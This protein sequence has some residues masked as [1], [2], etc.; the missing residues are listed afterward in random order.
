MGQENIELAEAGDAKIAAEQPQQQA[1]IADKAPQGTTYIAIPGVADIA[2]KYPDADNAVGNVFI[3]R[4]GKEVPL[5][6]HNNNTQLTVPATVDNGQ[7][8]PTL[9]LPRNGYSVDANQELPANFEALN[10]EEDKDYVEIQFNPQRLHAEKPRIKLRYEGIS[11]DGFDG[12]ATISCLTK[13][14]IPENEYR[15]L[16]QRQQLG[17]V[18]D[19]GGNDGA[20]IKIEYRMIGDYADLVIV[21]KDNSFTTIESSQKDS[22]VSVADGVHRFNVSDG[23]GYTFDPRI[24]RLEKQKD[25]QK[26]IYWAAINP[27]ATSGVEL[28]FD[29][30]WGFRRDIIQQNCS[31]KFDIKDTPAKTNQDGKQII[32]SLTIKEKKF[33]GNEYTL[34]THQH[35]ENIDQNTARIEWK[36]PTNNLLYVNH[37]Q[38]VKHQKA[39]IEGIL[40]I[41][42]AENFYELKKNLLAIKELA[43]SGHPNWTKATKEAINKIFEELQE[44][45]KLDPHVLKKAGL[46][47]TEDEA[48]AQAVGGIQFSRGA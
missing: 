22:G 31:D 36:L 16:E 44:Q 35:D 23:S 42:K 21:S 27:I 5:H 28:L 4:D 29:S 2:I 7:P 14:S 12:A 3:V 9:K 47:A 45:H 34:K 39:K 38:K 6:Q 24:G 33:W 26:F 11:P 13:P 40:P 20:N 8:L 48:P 18:Y 46:I 30:K 15:D 41:F 32:E 19:F 1:Q 17:R 43:T 25:G 10:Q 37:A